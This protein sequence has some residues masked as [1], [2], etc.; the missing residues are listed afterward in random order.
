MFNGDKYVTSGITTSIPEFL[1]LILW[2]TIETMSIKEKDY[3]QVFELSEVIQDGEK[4]QKINQHQEEPEFE[5]E[6]TIRT[7]K[8][9]TEKIYVID[10]ESHSTMM[11]ASE[12]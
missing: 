9:T 10:D 5:E 6:F 3:L 7:K 4:K 8:A 1:I 11:L 2:Y 12:Y